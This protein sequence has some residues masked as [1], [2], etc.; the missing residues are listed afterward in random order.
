MLNACIVDHP[1][2]VAERLVTVHQQA[3]GVAESLRYTTDDSID[4]RSLEGVMRTLVK[5]GALDAPPPLAD[6]YTTQF[7]P[8]PRP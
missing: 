6:L 3:P 8:V 2:N 4:P 1:K 5:L 7:V